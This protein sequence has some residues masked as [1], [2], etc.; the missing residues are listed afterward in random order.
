MIVVIIILLI[1]IGVMTTILFKQKEPNKA[2][3]GVVFEPNTVAGE[4]A[5]VGTALPG[6]AIPGWT[7]IKLS[8]DTLEA[9]V[10]LHNPDSNAG[11]YS[12]SFT[13][14]LADTGEE[15]FTTG[16]IEPGFKCSKVP[17]NVKLKK[18]EYPAVMFVQPYLQDETQT[19]LNNAEMEILLIVE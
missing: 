19:P 5:Q 6:V 2:A 3:T 10:S 4:N 11:Y 9:D 17:L 1:I 12:L 14:V 7:A 18:G 13:L 15:V 16:L 8:A